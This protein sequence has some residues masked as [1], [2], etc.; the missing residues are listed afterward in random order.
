MNSDYKSL[1]EFWNQNF[2][3]KEED[4]KEILNSINKDEDPE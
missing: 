3:L 2:I 4:K 1:K